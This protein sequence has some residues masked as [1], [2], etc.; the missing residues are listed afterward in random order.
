M[1]AQRPQ[2]GGAGMERLGA[3]AAP[4]SQQLRPRLV[5]W[6]ARRLFAGLTGDLRLHRRRMQALHRSVAAHEVVLVTEVHSDDG[7]VSVLAREFFPVAIHGSDDYGGVLVLVRTWRATVTSRACSCS[8]TG[9]WECVGSLGSGLWRSSAFTSFRMLRTRTDGEFFCV[10]AIGALTRRRA[11]VSSAVP[12]TQWRLVKLGFGCRRGQRYRRATRSNRSLRM[13]LGRRLRSCTRAT[14]PGW[15]LRTACQRFS[16]ASTVVALAPV[17][18]GRRL[19]A[20]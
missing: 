10:S 4:R 6:S 5:A 16:A 7:R 1:R 11:G 8:G 9:A 2:G 18:S 3:G 14:T 17:D 12:S 20:A 15:A 19:L 13:C